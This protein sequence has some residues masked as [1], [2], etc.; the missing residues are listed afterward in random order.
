MC[1]YI[2]I[3]IFTAS[4][5]SCDGCI[6]ATICSDTTGSY[7]FQFST[8]FDQSNTPCEIEF[9]NGTLVPNVTLMEGKCEELPANFNYSILCHICPGDLYTIYYTVLFSNIEDCSNGKYYITI[10]KN[11]T[12]SLALTVFI[13]TRDHPLFSVFLQEYREYARGRE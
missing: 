10:R 2:C 8:L 9:P 4:G 7:F 1:I 5:V 3:F 13:C 12:S 6:D 11:C